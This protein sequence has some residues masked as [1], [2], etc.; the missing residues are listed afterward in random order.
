[1][2]CINNIKKI[3]AVIAATAVLAVGLS[4]CSNMRGVDDAYD[5]YATTA[6]YNMTNN[7]AEGSG[8]SLLAAGLCVGGTSNTDSGNI[9]TSD[10]AA[11]AV[12]N[13]TKQKITFAKNIY[14]KVYPASTTKIMTA[15]LT[16]KYGDLN[17]IV[18]VS[19]T[20]VSVPTGSSIAGIKI[21]DRI[22]VRNL[23]YGL[24][25]C[26]GNDCANA[27][28]EYISGTAAK[29]AVL[30]NKEAKKLGAV[31]CHFV[32]PHGYPADNHYVTVYDMYLIFSKALQSPEF[33]KIISTKTEHVTYQNAAGETVSADYV[34]SNWYKTGEAKSP[35]GFT[36]I[37]G[38]TGSSDSSG[39]CLV[40]YSLN[41][42]KQPIISIV[43][44]SDSKEH[45]YALTNTLL[46]G[47]SN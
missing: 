32:N 43:M 6:E 37:G 36:I 26:S 18:T 35:S 44:K 42:K 8:T 33:R 34:N 7:P 17:D 12:F 19:S 23:L 9:D 4:G 13:T 25:L 16:L 11:A 22:S 28:A 39:Y 27:L 40:L 14:Q 3:G 41:K 21:G 46:T 31:G 15:Y 20:A 10:A 2:K 45:L 29:F 24:L 38:K 47:F 1:M 5:T 30:M